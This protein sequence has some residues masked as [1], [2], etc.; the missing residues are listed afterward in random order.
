MWMNFNTI[1]VGL[2]PKFGLGWVG[3]GHGGSVITLAGIMQRV[4]PS[5]IVITSSPCSS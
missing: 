3:L 2:H 1:Q 4:C 5:R